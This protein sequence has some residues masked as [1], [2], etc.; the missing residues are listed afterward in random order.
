MIIEL[1]PR[2]PFQVEHA[3]YI[4][5]EQVRTCRSAELLLVG[6]GNG[7]LITRRTVVARND[8][9]TEAIRYVIFHCYPADDSEHHW[10]S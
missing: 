9:P 7:T 3:T 2:E 6:P 10:T 4:D 1:P 5:N 8:E